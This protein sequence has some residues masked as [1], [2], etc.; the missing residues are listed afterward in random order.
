M[1]ANRAAKFRTIVADPPW[2]AMGDCDYRS[3]PWAS[4][5]GRRGRDTFF[6]YQTMTL[7][8]IYRLDVEALAEDEAHLYLWVT[9]G[10]N[11]VG[12]GVETAEAWGFKVVSEIVW[13]K[14]SFGLGKFPRPQHEI[15]L[16]ARRGSLPYQL[17]DVGSVIRWHQPR[18]KNNGGKIHSA[19]PDGFLDLVERASPG[20]YLE[21]FA[22]RARFG[23]SYWGNESLETVELPA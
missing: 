18:G 17:N 22:R 9:A 15:I 12:V 3:R 1:T 23:W 2:P 21:M 13:E 20:P 6:P 4:K 7:E 10:L 8:D 11:R 14:P 5:G 19:K 16:V